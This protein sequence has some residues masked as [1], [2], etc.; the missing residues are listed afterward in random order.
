LNV[1]LPAF[2]RAIFQALIILDQVA[3]WSTFQN[4]ARLFRQIPVPKRKHDIQTL[5]HSAWD[6]HGDSAAQSWA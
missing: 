4:G 6:H 3:Q 2:A 5:P 1:S